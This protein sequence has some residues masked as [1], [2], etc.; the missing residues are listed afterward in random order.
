MKPSTS[1]SSKDKKPVVILSQEEIKDR[2]DKNLEDINTRMDNR[3]KL[4]K[5]LIYRNIDREMMDSL[6]KAL[7]ANREKSPPF[8]SL[9]KRSKNSSIKK[10][11]PL[12]P[13]S[14]MNRTTQNMRPRN[15]T[16]VKEKSV[17]NVGHKYGKF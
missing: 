11:P 2:L 7:V 8:S 13:S 5:Q 9:K 15:K 3:M 12:N 4:T 10:L 14:A 1:Q 6:S 16:K 17:S